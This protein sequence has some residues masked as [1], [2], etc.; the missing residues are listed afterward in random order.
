MKK[1]FSLLLILFTVVNLASAQK[2]PQATKIL[3]AMSAKYKA[4]K[5]FKATFAQTMENSSSKMKETMEGDILVA[6]PKYRLKVSGQEIIS[7]GKLMWTYL[8]DV[9]EVTITETDAEAEAMAPS[10]IFE[11]YKKGYK[12]AYAGTET[13]A[14]EKVDVIEMAPEDRNNPIFKVRLYVSQKD[15]S[16]KSWQM[17]RNNGNRYTYAIKNFQAN[18]PLAAD[19]FS[20]NKAKYKG[21]SVVDLR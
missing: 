18:P 11:M 1:I 15:K 7:D 20:F 16:L 9:N 21:V 2:D 8:K 14:G 3:N 10:K 17:F 4:M 5:G 12:Y 19:A 6:G 13:R